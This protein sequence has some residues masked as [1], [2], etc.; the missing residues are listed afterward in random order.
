MSLIGGMS[1]MATISKDR[2]R[3]VA[4]TVGG[5][6]DGENEGRKR[7][8]RERTNLSLSPSN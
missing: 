1:E 2:K 4:G 6:E 7:K 8:V 5:R 3:R